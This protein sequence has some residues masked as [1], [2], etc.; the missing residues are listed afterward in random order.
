[1]LT[2]FAFLQTDGGDTASTSGSIITTVVMFAI[3]GG[4]FWFLLIR[5]LLCL[6]LILHGLVWLIVIQGNQS[7]SDFDGQLNPFLMLVHLVHS[8]KGIGQLVETI[9]ALE[10]HRAFYHDDE[11]R[12]N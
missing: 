8:L 1:M 2:I 6:W 4:L 5:G 3:I 12:H 10:S 7:V 9:C 11:N